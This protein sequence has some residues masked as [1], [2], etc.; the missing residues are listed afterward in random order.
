MS[1]EAIVPTISRSFVYEGCYRP[2]GSLTFAE[3][4]AW[5]LR[6]CGNRP[7][8]SNSSTPTPEAPVSAR[9]SGP[10]ACAQFRPHE[11]THKAHAIEKKLKRKA[12]IRVGCLTSAALRYAKRVALAQRR[13]KAKRFAGWYRLSVKVGSGSATCLLARG[14]SFVTGDLRAKTGPR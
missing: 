7:Q 2:R 11:C 10:V 4:S 1:I 5:G 12:R 3:R 9:R 8:A 14:R 13:V 6:S